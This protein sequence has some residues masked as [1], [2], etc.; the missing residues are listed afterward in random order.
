MN[1]LL[2]KDY[3]LSRLC[4]AA[5]MIFMIAPY[6]FF[7]FPYIDWHFKEAWAISTFV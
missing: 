4:I 7:F 3:R 5:G 1:T 6:L 2:W